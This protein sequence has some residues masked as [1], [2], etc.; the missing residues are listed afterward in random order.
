MSSSEI[1]PLK[2]AYWRA[3]QSVMDYIDCFPYWRVWDRHRILFIHIPKTAGTSVLNAFGARKRLHLDYSVYMM[4][5]P[6]RFRRY[7]KFCFVRNPWDRA[8]STYNYFKNGGAGDVDVWFKNQING[9]YPTFSSWVME[10]LD[11]S[12]IHEHSLLKPQYLYIFDVAGNCMV[13][14]VGKYE[15]LNADFDI[16]RAKIGLSKTLPY[17]NKSQESSSKKKIGRA[18]QQHYTPQ[19]ASRIAQLYARDA[20]QFGYTF[21]SSGG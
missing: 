11:E 9:R 13:D 7:Y 18:Y 8:F 12:R 5:D 17:L 16:V 4:A 10:F 6:N 15:N 20:A 19:M 2:Q 3:Y 1:S 14:F 21:D